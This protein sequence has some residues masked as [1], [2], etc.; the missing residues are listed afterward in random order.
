MKMSADKKT[1]AI[2]NTGHC[3]VSIDF[4]ILLKQSK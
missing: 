4:T 3:N 1:E 2:E